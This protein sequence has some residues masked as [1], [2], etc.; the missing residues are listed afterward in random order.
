MWGGRPRPQ[1]APRPALTPSQTRPQQNPT[2]GAALHL[3]LGYI[4][5]RVPRA[6]AP[7]RHNCF[8]KERS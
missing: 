8:F 7:H 5:E 3:I 4:E 6:A 1:P 2:G